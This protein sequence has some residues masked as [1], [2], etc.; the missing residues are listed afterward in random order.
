MHTNIYKMSD[1]KCPSLLSILD[2]LKLPDFNLVKLELEKNSLQD[3]ND[4]LNL[5][6]QTESQTDLSIPFTSNKDITSDNYTQTATA[7][8]S[9]KEESADNSAKEESTDNS[10]KEEST[11]NSTKEES[12]DNSTKES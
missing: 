5:N 3:I 10:T 1:E 4:F 11:D 9:T 7:D 12:A 8:N 2:F 6:A